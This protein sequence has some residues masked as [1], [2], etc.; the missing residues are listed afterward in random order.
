MHS[1]CSV[2]LCTFICALSARLKQE[3]R[4]TAKKYRFACQQMSCAL[5]SL[6]ALY[7]Q[8]FPGT[9]TG[10]P[11]QAA[12]YIH[13]G[14]FLVRLHPS[15]LYGMLRHAANQASGPPSFPCPCGTVGAF[16]EKSPHLH[17]TVTFV[18]IADSLLIIWTK[19]NHT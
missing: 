12:A 13:Y 3:Q 5:I 8:A 7:C 18:H 10:R 6:C 19:G 9:Q 2:L 4:P 16:S 15:I 17:S 14:T 1:T 11:S